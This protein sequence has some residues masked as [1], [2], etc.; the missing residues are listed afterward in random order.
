MTILIMKS[1]TYNC[2]TDS[3]THYVTIS[4]LADAFI[5]L[6]IRNLTIYH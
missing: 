6:Q 5:H 3:S 4:D 2:H 1:F